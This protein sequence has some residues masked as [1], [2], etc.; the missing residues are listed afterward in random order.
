MKNDELAAEAPHSLEEAEAILEKLSPNSADAFWSGLTFQQAETL[1]TAL[2]TRTKN[3]AALTVPEH[4]SLDETPAQTGPRDELP[5]VVN[6][7]YTLPRLSEVTLLKILETSPDAVVVIDKQG[8]IVLINAQTEAMFGY[9]RDELIGKKV[10]I[11]VPVRYQRGHVA[12]RLGFFDNP[13]LRAMGQ[14]GRPLFGLRKD[15]REFPVEISLSPL[16]TDVGL[17][18]TSTIRDVTQRMQQEA[19]RRLREAELAKLEARY[20]SLV[21][22]IPAVTFV[23]PFDEA[24]GELYVSPQIVDLLGFTQEEWLNDPVLWYRQ[25]H[26]EDRERWHREF[27]RTCATAQPFQAI[28]RFIARDGHTVWVHGEA[29]VVRDKAGRPI[30]LQ[31]VAFDITE[32]KEAE[33]NLK[34]LNR[35]LNDRIAARTEELQRSNDA[36][37]DYG[38]YM[39]HQLKKPIGRINDIING[40]ITKNQHDDPPEARLSNIQRVAGDMEKLVLGLLKYALVADK[41]NKFAPVDS[42]ALVREVRDEL[43]PDI[44]ACGAEVSFAFLPI[45]VAHR[46]SLKTV[47]FNLIE[48]ALKYRALQPLRV[49]VTAQLEDG[50]WLFRVSDNGMG[51]PKRPDLPPEVAGNTDYHK[52]IFAVGR[53]FHDKDPQGRKIPGHGIGLSYCQKVIEHHGGKIWIESEAGKG[54]TFL[55]TLPVG[56]EARKSG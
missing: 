44:Q 46:E 48:N 4:P 22:E 51:I 5:H 45:V 47:F 15:G 40:P 31:G 50:A 56:M 36:L 2:A 26:S 18:V 49:E 39:A 19:E 23:A 10:E 42:A 41:A 33:K 9:H 32:R 21:E 29:K 28:Y 17:L 8:V 43:D 55:F 11:L 53:R 13:R 14:A 6:Q 27:A 37:A 24:L 35:T 34:D 30:F 54:S 7:P 20:R 1:L 38:Y 12:Q 25:L 16:D 3:S 52:T